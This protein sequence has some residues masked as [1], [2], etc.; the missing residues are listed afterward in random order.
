ML[1]LNQDK[2]IDPSDA[3]NHPWIENAPKTKLDPELM[4]QTQQKMKNFRCQNQLGYAVLSYISSQLIA[5]DKKQNIIKAFK[6]L[7]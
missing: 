1:I 5:K 2:R 6:E 7:D 3:L 4:R